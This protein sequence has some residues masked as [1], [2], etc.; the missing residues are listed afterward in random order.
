MYVALSKYA[1]ALSD[2]TKATIL[3]P[4]SAVAFYNK[5][6]ACA[7][8]GRFEEA[9][10]AYSDAIKLKNDYGEAYVNWGITHFQLGDKSSARHDLRH[11]LE[12]LQFEPAKQFYDEICR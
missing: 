1:D 3:D 2:F 6:Y 11:A 5:G 8:L 4:F 10:A 9:V 12:T 7:N